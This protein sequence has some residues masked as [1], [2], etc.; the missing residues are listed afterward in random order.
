MAWLAR[1]VASEVGRSVSCPAAGTRCGCG[2]RRPN[3]LVPLERTFRTKA[4][5]DAALSLALAGQHRGGFV[6]PERGRD[7][8]QEYAGDWQAMHQGLAPGSRALYGQ[9]L[10]NHVLPYLGS[11]Y[12]GDIDR[13]SIERWFA[14]F[15]K[16]TTPGQRAKSYRVLKTILNHAVVHD[17]I[18]RNPCMIKGGGKEVTEE[19]PVLTITQVFALAK[20]MP[21]RVRTVGVA[22]RLRLSAGRGGGRAAPRG[23]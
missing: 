2:T 19:R 13:S 18:L 8:L 6:V 5:A 7:L 1:R 23:R 4:D 11:A 10:G 20:A 3:E 14:K 12:I 9:L 22:V 17:R 16:T 15:G 21:E